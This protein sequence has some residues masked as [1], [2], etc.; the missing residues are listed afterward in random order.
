VIDVNFRAFSRLISS[1]TNTFMVERNPINVKCVPSNS[2]DQPVYANMRGCTL[3]RGLTLVKN[4]ANHSLSYL[5][6]NL[7]K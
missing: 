4:V 5:L 2:P 1:S 6:L 7:I 3:E